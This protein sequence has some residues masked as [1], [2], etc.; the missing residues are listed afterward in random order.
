VILVSITY[1][2]RERKEEKKVGGEGEKET[3]L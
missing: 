1:H 3:L 2:G